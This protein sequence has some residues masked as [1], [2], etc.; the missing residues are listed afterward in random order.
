MRYGSIWYILG[1]RHIELYP[2]FHAHKQWLPGNT[3]IPTYKKSII[4]RKTRHQFRNRHQ[5]NFYANHLPIYSAD[6]SLFHGYCNQ[7]S[8]IKVSIFLSRDPVSIRRCCCC[9]FVCWLSVALS[10]QTRVKS[11]VSVYEKSDRNLKA[12]KN[13]TILSSKLNNSIGLLLLFFSLLSMHTD[14]FIIKLYFH[15]GYPI[16]LLAQNIGGVT[17]STCKRCSQ[18]TSFACFGRGI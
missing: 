4:E 12:T 3:A 7:C 6:A 17:Y 14:M 10:L 5:T 16:I 15:P 1:S 13:S 9:L 8:Y 18:Q 11:V 2:L